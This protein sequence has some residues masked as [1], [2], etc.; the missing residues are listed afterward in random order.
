[1]I[2]CCLNGVIKDNNNNNNNNLF[3]FSCHSGCCIS[4]RSAINFAV[5]TFKK[6]LMLTRK[7]NC[8]VRVTVLAGH[9]KHTDTMPFK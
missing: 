3:D 2:V 7:I 6:R 8:F 1:M 9:L 4:F 5:R